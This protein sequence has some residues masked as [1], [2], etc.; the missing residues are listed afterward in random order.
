MA[1]RIEL[2]NL[3]D[4]IERYRSGI[5]LQRLAKEIGYSR[6]CLAR[7]LREANIEIRS[8]SD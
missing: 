6:A 5:P 3:N 8:Y 7:R 1:R 2:A 4:I